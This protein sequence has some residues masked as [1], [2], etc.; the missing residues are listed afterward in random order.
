MTSFPIRRA[1]LAA[2]ALLMVGCQSQQTTEPVHAPAPAAEA[3]VPSAQE[4]FETSLAEGR[5]AE[6]EAQFEAL[7][8][9][10]EPT[11]LLQ[12][13]RRLSEAYLQE[14]QK[15][16]ESGDLDKAAKSLG[17]A[18][19]LMPKA[20][21][22]TTGLD[23]AIGKAREA[24]LSAVEQARQAGEQAQA[25]RQEQLRLLRQAAE[26]QAAATRTVDATPPEASAQ[27]ID[28]A[29]KRSEVSLPMLD[30][31][32]EAA[33]FERLDAVAADVV[34]FDRSVHIQVRSAEDLRRVTNLLEA[35][36]MK[37]D[38]TFKL[39]LSHAVKP[40]Q[41]PRLILRARGH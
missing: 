32:D 26:A 37:R 24:E 36:V 19:N 1:A 17:H 21:A 10:G 41:V 2:L 9:D 20:P 22:L 8:Q 34:T 7:Q 29:A 13:Q 28:P 23:G 33:L 11:V 15:A 12:A 35:R 5:L 4:Q 16:L 39:T 27:L 25:A 3:A 18:R 14:G 6:A 38:P 31:R 40:V 30:S